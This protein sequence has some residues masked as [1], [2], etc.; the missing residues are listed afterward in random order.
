MS[1]K[2]RHSPTVEGDSSS[3]SKRVKAPEHDMYY[4]TDC[5]IRL[6]D[7]N[8]ALLRPVFFIDPEKT[9]YISVGHYASRNCQPLVEIGIPKSNPLIL[10]GLLLKTMAE[11]LLAQCD[12]L[13]RDEYTMYWMATSK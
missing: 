12:A 3:E 2:K 13:C 6:F 4:N 9:K 11:H 5:I 8:R 7:P 1:A 10:T